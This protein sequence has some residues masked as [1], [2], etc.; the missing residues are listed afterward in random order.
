MV[1]VIDK[2]PSTPSHTHRVRR[3]GAWGVLALLA[4]TLCACAAFAQA[5][6][7][8]G[9]LTP[10][11][12]ALEFGK[13]EVDEPVVETVAF[14]NQTGETLA[15]KSVQPPAA[16]FQATDLPAAGRQVESGEVL[17]VRVTFT[18][19]EAGQFHESLAIATEGAGKTEVA[20]VALSASAEY[21]P[22]FEVFP[23]SLE[24]GAPQVGETTHGVATFFNAG[25]ETLEVQSVRAPGVPFAAKGLPAIGTKIT[26]GEEIR[27]EVSF[28]SS[29][30][31]TFDGSLEVTASAGPVDASEEV[32]LSAVASSPPA[33]QS[34]SQPTPQLPASELVS[35]DSSPPPPGPE[36]APT[37]TR[38]ALRATAARR[39]GRT[40]RLLVGYTLSAAG[41]I[42]LSVDRAETSHRCPRRAR[43]CLAWRA[44]KAKLTQSARAGRDSATLSLAR[45]SAGEYRLDATP[46]ARSGRAG[47]TQRLD[48]KL[49]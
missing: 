26:P 29:S 32:A 49:G 42:E 34:S 2:S 16:P 30:A 36:P 5:A 48:F 47:P 40:D 24:V 19:T 31:G 25:L 17:T 35:G 11:P 6:S 3:R 39:G 38:L 12:A 8:A 18:P 27:V 22:E 41:R 28:D 20:E 14:E 46:L 10:S 21:H 43:S 1:V 23:E 7:A 37:L 4:G 15:V 13:V 33:V 45:L 44:T 9:G